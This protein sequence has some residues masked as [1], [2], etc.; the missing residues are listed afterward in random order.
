MPLMRIDISEGRSNDGIKTMLDTV[1]SCVVDAFDVSDTDRYQ[2]VTENKP[3]RMIALDTGL[4]FEST[5]KVTF[6]Q[7]FT[8]PRT[9]EMK[10]EFYK[11]MAERPESNIGRDQTDLF[12]V[13]TPN[14]IG[15]WSFANGEAQYMTG[16]L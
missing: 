6:V 2:I 11:L 5:D 14:G 16:T 3:G 8:S 10:K 13:V 4:G 9:P 15:D 12:S 7:V 1:Q